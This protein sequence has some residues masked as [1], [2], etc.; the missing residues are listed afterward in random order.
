M[1]SSITP[2]RFPGIS[3][4]QT[5]DFF[6]PLV[7]DP[8]VQGRITCANVL[9]DLYAMG[10]ADCDN[11]LMLLG[12]A[13]KMEP[14]VKDAVT[15]HFMRGFHDLAREAGTAVTGGQT[16]QSPWYM[17][18]GVA[19]AV[20][21]SSEIIMPTHAVAGDVL[22]LTKPLG[23]QLAVNA[24]QWLSMQATHPE[25][26]ARVADFISPDEVE[27]AYE[28]AILSMARLNQTGARLMH[29]YDAHAATD[30][31]GF[32]ILGH[33]RNLASNQEAE[34]SFMIHTLPVIKK[35]WQV[36][37][38]VSFRLSLGFS[39]ETSGGLLIAMPR[40]KAKLFVQEIEDTDGWPAWIVGDVVEGNRTA[41]LSD[42]LK[43]VDVDYRRLLDPE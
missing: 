1:D 17:M 6:Y 29:K 13:R 20:V 43:V 12:V 22:V 35:M 9:S 21:S 15:T 10:V 18:G 40:D 32:G 41:S 19:S 8:Y 23:T 25:K 4:V 39:A 7:D 38:K 14:E 24:H 36:D 33:V 27:G 26:Y 3:L 30:V 16:V 5:T 42:D 28:T 34:V 2:T 11:M 37:A 31:T